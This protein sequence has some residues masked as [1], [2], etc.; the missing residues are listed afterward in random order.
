[1]SSRKLIEVAMPLEAINAASAREKSIR[2]GHPSTLHLWWA[3][4]PLAAAR[5]VLFCSLV[6]DPDDKNA[7]VAF[8]AA[9]KEL[10]KAQYADAHDTPRARLFDFIALLVQWE[11][12]NNSNILKTARKLIDL[13]TD[14]NPPPVYDPFAGGG[15]IPLEAQRLGLK[16]YA[17]DL[18]PVAVLINKA[19][20]EIPPKFAGRPPV[21]PN[22]DQDLV[23]GTY[24]GAQ[25]L[26]E[27]VRHYGTWMRNEAEKRIGHLYPKVKLPPEQ[28]GGEATVIAWIWAR[29]VRSP[30]PSMQEVWVPLVS[31]FYLSK[32][33]GNEA[34]VEPIIE[35]NSY[36][37][38]IGRGTPREPA[39]VASGTKLSRGANFRCLV[40][41]IPISP[42]HIKAEG[43]A[44]R[45]G[46]RLM[47][48]VADGPHGRVYIAPD[49]ETERVATTDL[50][51]WKPEA[52]MPQ[53]PR[54]FSPPDYG[55][56]TYGDL[57]TPRQLV[58]LTTF[59]DLVGETRERVLA[60]AV[61]A[62]MKD[63][64]KGIEEGGAGAH[65]YAD[66]V[67]TYLAFAVDRSAD[68][69]S[70]IATWANG[71]GFIRNTFSRQAI[72]MTWDFAE[73]NPLSDSTGNFGGAVEW[74]QSVVEQMPARHEAMVTQ[75]DAQKTRDGNHS[76]IVSTDPPYYD[77]IGYADLSDYFYVWLRQSLRQTYPQLFQ[78]ML[79]PKT[80][81]LIATPY[82]FEGS[83][84]RARAFFENGLSNVFGVVRS[85]QNPNYP[86]TVYY[87][88]KQAD[89]SDEQDGTA[90]SSTGWETMLE[91]LISTGYLITGTWPIRTER[92]G[93]TIGIGANALASSIVLSCRLRASDAPVTTRGQFITELRGALTVAIRELQSTNIPPV[94][95]EQSAIG[96]GMAVYS[97]Y[98][99]VMEGDGAM[100]VRSALAL[101][102]Q[103]IEEIL[104]GDDADY[105]RQTRWAISWF[106]Q[107]GMNEGPFGDAEILSKAKDIG[108]SA[109]VESGILSAKAGKVRILKRDELDPDWAPETDATPT[110]WEMTQHM[111]VAHERDG[112]PGASSILAKLG[113][114]AEAAK[115]L[116]YRLYALCE[117]QGW[118]QEAIAYN[119]LIASWPEIANLAVSDSG[120][121]AEA[122]LDF[123]V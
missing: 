2:H 22:R 85:T 47:A 103:T 27:D 60:D 108:V 98:S 6:D 37:F 3:R 18:N 77:N 112:D 61:A 33:K 29:T 55:M 117:R 48:V 13:C 15:T 8:V 4:R 110:V 56:R 99:Q 92:G 80:E 119:D 57:F 116:C 67:A 9:C 71:S 91:A 106:S 10:P 84:D 96:P 74:I 50:T 30:N 38:E 75:A 59:S 5:A 83:R 122:E 26:A 79:V 123:G 72:P 58:A 82:R 109:L 1:M 78:T 41:G 52:D 113:G 86:L 94:D 31:S 66:A 63:D 35:G 95:F 90:R 73:T 53:N 28:G 45:L 115:Q 11:S 44:G 42:E 118:A 89:E 36:R 121:A 12:S 70:T 40:S 81:E 100:T 62:G 65:A 97:K 114:K 93:R 105:D 21:H 104:T 20:I 51:A 19:M 39:A 23:H 69:W 14:G 32:K 64:G 54:W 68:Y 88:F 7:P 25:G 120:R 49:E 24:S 16:A 102:N 76:G 43:M 111:I 101:I 87:A 34:W 107:Y 17:S 46:Q